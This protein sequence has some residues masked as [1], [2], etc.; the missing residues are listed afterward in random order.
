MNKTYLW[1]KCL[2]IIAVINLLLWAFAAWF[3]MDVHHLSLV[4]IFLSGVYVSTCAFRS[5]FLRVDLERY[6]LIDTAL[7]SVALGR[8][9]AT[10]AEM[11]FSIQ[12]ALIIYSLGQTLNSP[13]IETIAYS[14][15]PLIIF[16]QICCWYATLTLNHFWHGIEESD[17]VVMV[18]LSAGCLIYGF[19]TLSGVQ[20]MLLGLGIICCIG[21]AYIMLFLDIPMYLT[22]RTEHLRSNF[23]YLSLTEGIRD[24]V[25]RR[26]PTSDWRIWKK[27][28]VWITSYF[29]FGVWLSIGMIW[30][31]FQV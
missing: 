16:A 19:D 4:Q 24:A 26:I 21:C 14:I 6:C 7:S 8:T 20:S 3:R 29:T 18:V 25:Y 28:A 15:V 30:V 12:C 10:I 17:W 5:F 1:W 11:C 13:I 9:C 27:E 22:R 2:C 23:S 31:D